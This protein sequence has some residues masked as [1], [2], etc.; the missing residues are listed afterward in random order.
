MDHKQAPTRDWIESV[1]RRFPT[2]ATVDRALTRKLETRA[3]PPHRALSVG[4]VADLLHRYLA[5][6]IGGAFRISDIRPLTGGSSKE[7]FHFLLERADASGRPGREP[8]VLR[9][10]PSES[11]VE[12]HRLREFQAM[13]AIAGTVRVP[14]ALWVDAEGEAFGRP[15]MILRFVEGVT[16]PPADGQITGPRQSYGARYRDLL[17]PQFIRDL[18]RISTFDW[19]GAD[20]SSLDKPGAGTAEAAI[21]A[22]DWQAR[23]WEEDAVE[24][25]PLI[26]LAEQWLRRNAPP[27]DHVSLVHADYRGGN[28]LFRPEDGE[29]TA[30][31][32]WELV[33]L[34]DRHE[35]LAHTL[36]SVF[37][38]PDENG[39]MLV[40]GLCTREDFLRDYE[41]QTGLPVDRDRLDYYTILC[42]WRSSIM[43]LG[44]AVRCAMGGKT[45]QDILLTW[46]ATLAPVTLNNLYIALKGRL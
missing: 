36:N 17:A 19:R 3:G 30:Q 18:A 28:F 32:D 20:L 33:H 15:A 35:D 13:R 10:Q 9:L 27:V 6:R 11:I 40:S 5:G 29:I 22:I 44:T 16:K 24:G 45:H 39:R 2:E 42:N 46:I 34:G 21:W 41:R 37:M 8:L 38:E 12:T 31:L 4:E 7:Q 14:E 23:V 26:T 25:H 1:R 43:C